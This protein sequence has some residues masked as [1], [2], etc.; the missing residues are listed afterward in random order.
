MTSTAVSR[1]F[2]TQPQH[3]CT[4]HSVWDHCHSFKFFDE[5]PHVA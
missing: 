3:V 5:V 4:R 1:K 2:N